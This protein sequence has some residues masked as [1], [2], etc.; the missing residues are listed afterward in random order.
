MTMRGVPLLHPWP[1]LHAPSFIFG[2]PGRSRGLTIMGERKGV[3]DNGRR[4]LVE[5]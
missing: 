2:P 4:E 5:V 1:S 3:E